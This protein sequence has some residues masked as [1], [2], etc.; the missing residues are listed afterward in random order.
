M[1]G[2]RRRRQAMARART[3]I[4]TRCF[5]ELFHGVDDVMATAIEIERGPVSALR[6]E[7]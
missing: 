7:Q 3:Y 4:Q 1:S 5:D 2:K 6:P